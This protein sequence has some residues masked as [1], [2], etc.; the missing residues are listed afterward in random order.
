MIPIKVLIGVT[1]FLL[2]IIIVLLIWIAVLKFDNDMLKRNNLWLYEDVIELN[3]KL[4]IAM[5]LPVDVDND[6]SSPWLYRS[7]DEEPKYNGYMGLG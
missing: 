2:L 4:K 3:A 6:K 1:I 7:R 5:G